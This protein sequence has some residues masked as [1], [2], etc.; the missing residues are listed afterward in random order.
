METEYID[1][2]YYQFERIYKY[3]IRLRELYI[4]SPRLNKEY[5]NEIMKKDEL[6]KKI[7]KYVYEPS[8]KFSIKS[9]NYIEK[10]KNNDYVL[11]KKYIDSIFCILDESIKQ[12]GRRKK[13][14]IINDLSE[15][16]N[17]IH[18]G[19]EIV[20][21]ILDRDLK[22][23]VNLN[24]I[25]KYY[26][27]LLTPCYVAKANDI[28]YLDRLLYPA[29]AYDSFFINS[30]NVVAII[31]IDKKNNS[32]EFFN[33]RFTKLSIT[34]QD[35]IKEALDCV[36]FTS[37]KYYY[38]SFLN[39]PVLLKTNMYYL[40]DDYYCRD[41]RFM[42]R[43][44]RRNNPVE[45]KYLKFIVSDILTVSDFKKGRQ[46]LYFQY[47]V[48][49]PIRKNFKKYLVNPDYKRIENQV[50]LY[51]YT[52][53]LLSKRNKGCYVRS[54]NTRWK[55]ERI[56]FYFF[57]NK[58]NY[59]RL[60]IDDIKINKKQ[61][62]IKCVSSD[63]IIVDYVDII[64]N[65]D[66]DYQ[67]GQVVNIRFYKLALTNNDN[68][69]DMIN[70]QIIDISDQECESYQEIYDRVGQ[71]K[72]GNSIRNTVC[73]TRFQQIQKRKKSRKLPIEKNKIKEEKLRDDQKIQ[74]SWK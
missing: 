25:N 59:C 26:K 31:K 32:V 61:T 19:Y 4:K 64:V 53:E 12:D 37:D 56:L 22:I 58:I 51:D 9:I 49:H 18:Y 10:K 15:I 42:M 48:E 52:E 29:I 7:I 6:F 65:K 43:L 66:L 28:V 71:N 24:Y 33:S 60:K 46:F 67:V 40:K 34:N 13:D 14:N 44:L 57:V 47:N 54:C 73:Q 17:S 3:I 23:N 70:P 62:I 45:Y 35:I 16:A 74:D 20:N 1:K 68:I 21:M 8:I 72:I 38:Q 27:G 50:Q 2:Q 5:F 39:E 63:G 55:N 11:D 41:I 36:N 30:Y 69:I